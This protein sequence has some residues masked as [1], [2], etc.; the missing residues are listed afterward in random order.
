M[1]RKVFR[2]V[3]LV[4]ILFSAAFIF[5]NSHQDAERSSG[6]SQGVSLLVAQTFVAGFESLSPEEQLEEVK[7]IE[8][9]LREIAHGCEFAMLAFFVY[10]FSAT[11]CRSGKGAL[12]SGAGSVAFCFLY[13]L[14]DEWHQTFVSGRAA[15]WSDVGADSAGALVGVLFAFAFCLILSKIRRSRLRRK[16][17]QEEP[18]FG[19]GFFF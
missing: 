10:G 9:P 16:G 18:C 6:R 5:L 15:E 4:G 12:I 11:F 8:G 3:F 17:E 1:F 2:F 7:K 13:A 19:K 14:S